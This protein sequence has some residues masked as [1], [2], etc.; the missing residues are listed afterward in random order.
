MIRGYHHFRK[1]PYTFGN[2][3][4]V[5]LPAPHLLGSFKVC[6]YGLAVELQTL[7]SDSREQTFGFQ[8][9]TPR[10]E[11]R[12]PFFFFLMKGYHKWETHL[13]LIKP[14][15][16]AESFTEKSSQSKKGM[17]AAHATISL[18]LLGPFG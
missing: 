16:L 7:P 13:F 10:Q 3:F 17:S 2:V 1:P 8:Q 14:T 4:H 18:V 5:F 12:T 15:S 9:K 11:N 6:Q